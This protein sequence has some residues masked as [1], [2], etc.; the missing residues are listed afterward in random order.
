[1]KS[2]SSRLTGRRLK[3]M[4]LSWAVMAI[5]SVALY[6]LILPHEV[7]EAIADPTQWLAIV[8]ETFYLV[9]GAVIFWLRSDDW[10][11]WLFSLLWMPF[12]MTDGFVTAFGNG[13]IAERLDLILAAITSTLLIC[14]LY[15]FPDGR[16]VPRWTRWATIAMAGIQLWRVFYEDVYMTKFPPV[17]GLFFLS[18]AVAQIYRYRRVSTETQRHQIKWV[19]FALAITALPLGLLALLIGANGSIWE[20]NSLFSQVGGFIWGM[21]IIIFPLSIAI[22]IL[23]FHLWDIDIIIRKTLQYTAVT[24]LLALIYFGSVLLL[25]RLF[26][27]VT[28][29]VS[30]LALVVSTLLIAALF[31]P[32]RRRIQDGIDRRFYRKKYNAQQVLAQFARTARDETDMDALLAEL[33]RVIQETLQPEGVKVWLHQGGEMPTFGKLASL[34][35]NQAT[36]RSLPA[37][38]PSDPAHGQNA[39]RSS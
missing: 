30:P 2:T 7:Q 13:P 16:F 32:L 4:R 18:I 37:S 12:L 31:A 5:I 1:M 20:T 10:V 6:L 14:L 29:Q 25:Q 23:R 35:P 28:G 38:S 26:S 24:A 21:F 8:T 34:H 36:M 15:I 19:V 17:M 9:L 39:P 33:E 3:L 22:S 11:A 27:S